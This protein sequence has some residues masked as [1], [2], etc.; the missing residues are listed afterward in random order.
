MNDICFLTHLSRKINVISGKLVEIKIK[1]FL[2][3]HVFLTDVP[4]K[5]PIF[6]MAF[7]YYNRVRIK[8]LRSLLELDLPHTDIF[9]AK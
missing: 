2:Y 5:E 4:T 3:S 6:H 8:P 9:L 7:S 1:T